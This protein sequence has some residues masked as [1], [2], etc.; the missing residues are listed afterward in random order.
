MELV[1]M[2]FQGAIDAIG[3]ARHFLAQKDVLARSRAINK[4]HRIL[5]ELSVSLDHERGGA[6]SL[7]LARLY[8]YMSRRL[9]EANTRQADP[10]LEEVLRLLCTLQ[11]GWNGIS[12]PAREE[13]AERRWAEP[14]AAAM[15][16][17]PV[18]YESHA[19]SF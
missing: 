11:E 17:E 8:D 7:E 19:W 16:P 5:T 9:I 6:L 15:P 3:E 1:R 12:T 13:S 4:A 14:L 2:L 18:G 10:P